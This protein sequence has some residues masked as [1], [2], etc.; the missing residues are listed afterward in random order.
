MRYIYELIKNRLSQIAELKDVQW[1]TGQYAQNGDQSLYID[2]AAYIEFMP[3]AWQTKGKNLQEAVLEFDIHAMSEAITEDDERILNVDIAHLELVQSIYTKLQAYQANLS[4][5]PAFASLPNPPQIINTIVRTNTTPD[6]SFNNI[7]VT[8][9][10]FQC[11]VQDLTA[12]ATLQPV[13]P[14]L[15]LNVS[16]EQNL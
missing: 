4:D 13:S 5:L 10:R 12:I 2:S 15:Q 1:Y 8:I 16:I 7:L 6:H 11:T 9:Q 3:I 14:N